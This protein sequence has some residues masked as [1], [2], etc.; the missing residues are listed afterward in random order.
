MVSKYVDHL[1]LYRQQHHEVRLE[2]AL[3]II[4]NLGKWMHRERNMVLPKSLIGKA[5]E[6]C[7]RLWSSLLT[8]LENGNYHI[9]N[10]AIENKIRPV[11]IGR[12]NYLFAGSHN[13]AK[14]TAMFYTF[15]ANC[16]LN[17]VNPEKWLNKVLE[18]IADY[19]CNKLQDLFPENLEV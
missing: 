12:K 16:K 17:G 9:N 8:Y 11:A 2:E 13:G 18:V 3:P 10:N 5:I 1:P 14:R 4:N 19:P 7:T 6:Y 15:F